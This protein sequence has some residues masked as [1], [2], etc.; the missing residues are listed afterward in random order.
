MQKNLYNQI[1]NKLNKN[2]FDYWLLADI[3]MERYGWNYN[4][5]AETDIPTILELARVM[6]KRAKE[7]EKRLNKK[8]SRR[9]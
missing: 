7:E 1:K 3:F 9:R 5:F 8:S 2:K 6:E 4:E